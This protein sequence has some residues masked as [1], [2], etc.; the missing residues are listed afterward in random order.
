MNKN[1]D[2]ID[3]LADVVRAL[4]DDTIDVLVETIN[5]RPVG[6]NSVMLEDTPQIPMRREKFIVG[7]ASGNRKHAESIKIGKDIS[8]KRV[9]RPATRVKTENNEYDVF[10]GWYYV[11][12]TPLGE[13]KFNSNDEDFLTV[14]N[15]ALQKYDRPDSYNYGKHLFHNEKL[16]KIYGGH[17]K[18]KSS[19]K[20]SK[21]EKAIEQL[22]GL[23]VEPDKL[24]EFILEQQ[25][26]NN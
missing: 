23:G 7:G 25:R 3:I 8:I 21:Y 2:D 5:A 26:Q 19:D 17:G 11:V 24:A 10:N 6:Y 13:A 1:I 4:R 22:K 20:R 15:W 14:W 12:R 18:L 9:H 16:S